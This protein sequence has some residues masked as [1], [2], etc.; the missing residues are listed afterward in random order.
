M[1]L[2]EL[3]PLDWAGMRYQIGDI[4]DIPESHER[5]G[6]LVRG[7]FVRYDCSLPSQDDKTGVP[8]RPN[9]QREQIAVGR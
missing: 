9:A 5:L 3:K 8:I 1:R 4:L 7:G 2:R 6:G